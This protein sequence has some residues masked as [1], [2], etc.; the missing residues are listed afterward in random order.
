MIDNIYKD[1]LDQSAIVAITDYKGSITYVNEKFCEISGYSQKEL[2]G[3]NHRILNSGHH[4]PNFFK[5]MWATISGGKLWQG[6]IKN[7]NKQGNYYWVYTSII[8]IMDKNA[9]P[10]QYISIRFETTEKKLAEEKLKLT[11]ELLEKTNKIARIGSWMYDVKRQTFQWSEITKQLYGV[12][13]DFEPTYKNTLQFYADGKHR[14]AYVNAMEQAV[15]E[16]K[17]FDV[18]LHVKKDNADVCLRVIGYSICE[19]SVCTHINGM[20]QDISE[21][22]K[23]LQLQAQYLELQKSKEVIE[24]STEEKELFLANM[25]H[26]IRTPLNAVVG[27]S[28]LLARSENFNKKQQVYVKAILSNSQNLLSIVNN[29]LEYSKIDAGK[30]QLEQIAFNL[31][32]KL[33][34]EII[35]SLSVLANEK[36]LYLAFDVPDNFPE[37]LIGDEVSIKQIISNLLSNAIKFTK[38]GGVTLSLAVETDTNKDVYVKFSVKDTGIGI[39]KNK[40]D[41][42]FEMFTQA[43]SSTTRKYGGTG[44]GLSIVKKLIEAHK[45]KIYIESKLNEGTE[46]YFTIKFE[47]KT[48][49]IEVTDIKDKH[50]PIDN[51]SILLV[52]DNEFNQMVAIDTLL[53]WSPS[54]KID[55]AENGLIA[56]QKLETKKYDLVLMDIQM[57]IMDGHA[58]TIHIRTKFPSPLCNIPII[59]MTARASRA[60][61]EKLCKKSGMND[62]I[63][64]PF[65]PEKLFLKIS[66]ALSSVTLTDNKNTPPTKIVDTAAILAFTKGNKQLAQKMVHMF[67]NDMPQTLFKLKTAHTENNFSTLKTM[68]HSTK[69]SY[70]Y[71]GMQQLTEIAKQIE[72]N[73]EDEIKSE[74][75]ALLLNELIEKTELAYLE[76]REF[77]VREQLN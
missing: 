21:H 62:Y 19:N 28:N 8:P 7:K 44:L 60:Y 20:I 58:A 25:S 71:L 77:L 9:K 59:A 29:I 65:E 76:L 56:L 16:G 1:A 26:E 49:N 6:E 52:E 17:T 39:L 72:H 40:Q 22:K 24:Q 30:I 50:K 18:E 75:T 4:P 11:S 3:Q 69:P 15:S 57:P 32:E 5:Q 47:K 53:G 14:E 10:E 51:M 61:E 37:E 68:V 66:Q 42:I 36:G 31:K 63:S 12:A 27:L 64:K 38:K 43:S 46:F 13:P 2:L 41:V 55:V 54:T 67:L 45:S 73:A 74:E 70:T 48:S 33:Q 34:D 23:Q 35:Q